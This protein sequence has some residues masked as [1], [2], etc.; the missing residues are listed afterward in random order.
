MK[1][2]ILTLL[3]IKYILLSLLELP[4]FCQTPLITNKNQI[5]QSVRDEIVSTSNEFKN[6]KND[7]ANSTTTLNNIINNV[8]TQ[9]ANDTTTLNN[10]INNLA[11]QVAN[12]TT[13]LRN[14]LINERQ[15]RIQ[16]DNDLN[17]QIQN[18]VSNATSQFLLKGGDTT[19]GNYTFNGGIAVGNLGIWTSGNITSLGS[20]NASQYL[21]NGNPLPLGGFSY[22]YIGD[23][24][25]IGDTDAYGRKRL[26]FYDTNSVLKLGGAISDGD[27]LNADSE[28][29][30]VINNSQDKMAIIKADRLGLTRS[31]D[32]SYY[33]FG[34]DPDKLFY[35]ST[36]TTN[37]RLYIDN[38]T[39][40]IGIGTNNP[41][42]K[43]DINGSL[44]IADGTQGAGKVLTSDANGFASWQTIPTG[45][46]SSSGDNLG[47]HI[48]TTTL[49]M[50]GY[51]ITNDLYV[52]NG[53]NMF[54]KW[55]IGQIDQSNINDFHIYVATI[56]YGT[57]QSGN[58][59]TFQ[60]FSSY[61]SRKDSY[62][63]YIGMDNVKYSLWLGIDSYNPITDMQTT[64]QQPFYYY[65]KINGTGFYINNNFG[66][67]FGANYEILTESNLKITANNI[68][69]TENGRIYT[70]DW[71]DVSI[72][73]N[74]YSGTFQYKVIG[75]QT[76]INAAITCINTNGCSADNYLYAITHLPNQ[77]APNIQQ[78]THQ[79]TT[80][81]QLPY[82]YNSYTIEFIIVNDGY[83]YPNKLSYGQDGY[84]DF[85]FRNKL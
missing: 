76:C 49:N 29:I 30:V 85:C 63:D 10:K 62:S 11:T 45:S 58:T 66:G 4:L 69:I 59:D 72:D 8:A 78:I 27:G 43:L 12:D 3:A 37:T 54:L 65:D 61:D 9:V 75:D 21:L 32:S 34:V 7:V 13:T 20:I 22:P 80:Y 5:K 67:K 24:L 39:G 70:Q 44:R 46:G 2:T 79:T 50:N 71:T 52:N 17:S 82:T 51:P 56:T 33:Y 25:H 55:G 38:N 41:Q 64:Q 28:G 18:I 73:T 36:D 19:N 26:W 15:E 60:I 74:Y 23:Y 81:T 57:A 48:A 14:D 53:T 77:F 1:K 68:H 83:I 31:S 40:Y 6:L 84:I 16:N 47:N 35:K 42:A